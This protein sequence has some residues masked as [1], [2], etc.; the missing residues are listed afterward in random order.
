MSEKNVASPMLVEKKP[1]PQR[2]VHDT[3]PV[4]SECLPASHALH[5]AELLT[6]EKDP[7]SHGGQLP[8]A[9]LRYVPG[10]QSNV[11]KQNV[12]PGPAVVQRS[13]QEVQLMAPVVLE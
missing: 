8:S 9:M 3:D 7:G 11:G 12:K 5:D 13:K 6:A 2:E 4:T 1:D 10:R